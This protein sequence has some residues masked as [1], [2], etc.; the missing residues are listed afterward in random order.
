MF[1][2]NKEE[3]KKIRIANES[4]L[5]DEG[6]GRQWEFAWLTAFWLDELVSYEIQEKDELFRKEK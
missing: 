3:K 6:M 1:P 4:V 5:I 2:N